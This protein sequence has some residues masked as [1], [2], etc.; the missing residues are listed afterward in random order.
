MGLSM[1]VDDS[2]TIERIDAFCDAVPRRRAR[3]EEHGPLVMFVPTG[4]GFPYYARPRRGSTERVTRDDIR[5]VRARQRELLIP[6]SF[7]WIDEAAPTM[8]AAA[9][10]GGLAARA[11]PLMMLGALAPAPALATEPDITVRLVSPSDPDL[12]PHPGRGHDADDR[13]DGSARDDHPPPRR[14]QVLMTQKAYAE[15]LRALYLYT[16]AYHDPSVAQIVSGA[17]ADIAARVNDLLLPIVKGVGSEQA[18][19][20]LT[21]SL[22]TFGG[23]GFLQDYP[24]EQYIRDSKID[25]CMRAPPRS[26]RRTSSSARSP[27]TGASRS[28]TWWTRS[29]SSSPMTARAVNWR[30]AGRSWPPR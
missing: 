17:D 25:T 10:D 7:E 24:I 23:S 2:S 30:K 9:P 11:H 4:P 14:P 15:G 8:T 29:R 6:E 26:R 22:Q 13:Q 16:A 21:E 20:C 28:S 5:A 12:D 27:A 3:A 1:G 19:Q 18:Y